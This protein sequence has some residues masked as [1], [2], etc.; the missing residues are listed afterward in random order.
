MF[1]KS[2]YEEILELSQ[3]FFGKVWVYG[4]ALEHKPLSIPDEEMEIFIFVATAGKKGLV[5][6]GDDKPEYH[7]GDR[8]RVTEGP[9]KGAEGHI[10][11][12]KKDRRLIVAIRGVVAVATTFIHPSF[13]EI[14]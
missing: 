5:Y 2:T 14:V 6:L 13:L 12:I 7:V 4:D 10:K 11:R 3:A 9:F 1:C 8:V